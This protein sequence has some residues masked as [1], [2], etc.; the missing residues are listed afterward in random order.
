MPFFALKQ[1]AQ[2]PQL[3][4]A[5]FVKGLAV[6]FSGLLALLA[7]G[8]IHIVIDIAAM[9]LMLAGFVVAI[10]AYIAIFLSRFN[11]LGP[12]PPP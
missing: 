11:R 8:G 4:W 5:R 2:Q 7:L 12:P 10:T 1:L 6:F 9:T 3:A